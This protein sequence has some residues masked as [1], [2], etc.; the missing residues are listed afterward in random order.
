MSSNASPS[1]AADQLCNENSNSG[2]FNMWNVGHSGNSPE[3]DESPVPGSFMDTWLT[4]QQDERRRRDEDRAAEDGIHL[5]DEETLQSSRNPESPPQSSTHP[6]ALDSTSS[7]SQRVEGGPA[8]VSRTVSPSEIAPPA[9]GSTSIHQVEG[10]TTRVSPL[11]IA[12][13]ALALASTS[14]RQVEGATRH[15]SQSEIA[16]PALGSTSTHQVEGAATHILPSEIAPLAST[17]TSAQPVEGGS[18]HQ[19]AQA[20]PLGATGQRQTPSTRFCGETWT[21][22]KNTLRVWM[23]GPRGDII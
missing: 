14:T 22:F 4:Q 18:M 6:S 11:E 19:A 5:S 13:Q 1:E 2:K 8:N 20:S 21:W 23:F 10:A 17:S 3:P 9:L 7:N 15:I 16:P 12:S